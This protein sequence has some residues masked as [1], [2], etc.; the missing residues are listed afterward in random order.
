M[1]PGARRVALYAPTWPDPPF[2]MGG[3]AIEPI[4]YIEQFEADL[5]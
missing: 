5:F 3:H 4:G 2:H 1:A